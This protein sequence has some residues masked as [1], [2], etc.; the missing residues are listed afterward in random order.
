LDR[1]TY[2]NIAYQCAKIDDEVLF[3]Q[4]EIKIYNHE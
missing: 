4:K 3:H 1:Y 2:S